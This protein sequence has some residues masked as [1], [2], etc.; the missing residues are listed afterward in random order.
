[1]PFPM[2]PLTRKQVTLCQSKVLILPPWC[3][4][5]HLHYSIIFLETGYWNQLISYVTLS[6]KKSHGTKLYIHD[7]NFIL[8]IILK[9]M[10]TG[11]PL[12]AQA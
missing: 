10:H 1:M 11:S 12:F 8:K 2:L 9:N 4:P 3:F 6:R 7:L 5:N